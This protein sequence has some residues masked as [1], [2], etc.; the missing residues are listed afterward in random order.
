MV[1]LLLGAIL[2]VLCGSIARA[3]ESGEVRSTTVFGIEDRRVEDVL[4]RL[5]AR[6]DRLEEALLILQERIVA[7]TETADNTAARIA[8][9]D[10]P[11]VALEIEQLWAL[12][13]A[14]ETENTQLREELNGLRATVD[15]G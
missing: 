2:V 12:V 10:E 15:G 4:V 7:V 8:R 5:S 11:L 14:L 6:Q 3:Q 13:R 9:G 1:P